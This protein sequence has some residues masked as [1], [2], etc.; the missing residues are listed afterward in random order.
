MKNRGFR[1][2]FL[3]A[4]AIGSM[5]LVS[6]SKD[7]SEY[8]V[9]A[10]D[11]SSSI[12]EKN[13][14]PDVG[15]GSQID[16]CI[17]SLPLEPLSEEEIDALNVMR[18][19]ELLAKDVYELLYSLYNSQIFSNISESE[20][21]HALAVKTLLLKYELPD[22]AENHVAG[23]FV[24]PDLQEI[25]NQL[26]ALG[27]TSLISAFT[28]GATIEDMDIY[29]L[30]YHIANDVDNLDILYVFENLVKGSRNHLRSFYLQLKSKG[31]IYVPQYISQELFDQIINSPHE[32]GHVDCPK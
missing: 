25:Y 29:D 17:A 2:L 1:M 15:A 12:I 32:T 4:V 7:T 3:I 28:V 27:K 20:T 11:N 9:G 18:E 19:E 21:Q 23:V 26:V 31:V 14:T 10:Q 24:N 8:N 16:G 6:C 13:A 5:Q 30:E 22:P